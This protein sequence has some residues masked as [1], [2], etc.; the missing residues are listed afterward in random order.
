MKKTNILICAFMAIVLLNVSCKKDPKP[1]QPITDPLKEVKTYLFNDIMSKWYYWYKNIPNVDASKQTDINSYFKAL[2]Y[3]PIDRWSHMVDNKGW[4]EETTGV[5][6]T[7]GEEWGQNEKA[8]I[9][10]KLVHEGSPM[11]KKGIKRGFK[12]THLNGIDVMSYLSSDAGVKELIS[13]LDRDSN[14]FTFLDNNG[15]VFGPVEITAQEIQKKSVYKTLVF[16]SADYAGLPY[17]VGYLN[18]LSFMMANDELDK[19]FATFKAENVEVLILDLRYNGGGWISMAQ[20]L[21]NYICPADK[22]NQILL[23]YRYNDKIQ[24]EIDKDPKYKE[25]NTVVR[26]SRLPNSLNL[27]KLYILTSK[28]TA[29][30]SEVNL[31]G[32]YPLME[33]HQVGTQSYGKP[34]GMLT[35]DY[36]KGTRND[37]ERLQYVF[38][39]ITFYDVNS[40]GQEIPAG[41][42]A[43][44]GMVPENYGGKT[45]SEDLTQDFGVNEAW[46]KACLNHIVTNTWPK[47][48]KTRNT[49]TDKKFI[50][51]PE[52]NPNYG[53]LIK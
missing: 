8:E 17:K 41:D 43:G 23:Q 16:T 19:A 44:S 20:K 42:K 7:Y 3:K 32:L 51:M 13:I 52:D 27:K 21:C 2:L 5:S 12:L 34:T 33:V 49:A 40:L 53:W 30:A 9:F 1:E 15:N 28:G 18:Y 38:S 37:K 45:I 6:K 25:E 48:A 36:P 14:T 46:V 10:V 26:L 29:S 22:E 39:P 31:N 11:D 24:A 50:K 47:S 35:F 4:F